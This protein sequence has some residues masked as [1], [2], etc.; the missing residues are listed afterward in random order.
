MNWPPRDA[1]EMTKWLDKYGN[2]TGIAEF[3]GI[4][5][6]AV[7]ECRLRHGVP[8]RGKRRGNPPRYARMPEA[9]ISKLYG[10]RRY[11]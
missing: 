8:R 6:N 7:T 9:E 5:R 2:D 10:G 11:R 1:D 3:I 4:T